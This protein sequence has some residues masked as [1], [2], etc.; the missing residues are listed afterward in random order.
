MTA[1]TSATR[2]TAKRTRPLT[3]EEV[4]ALPAAVDLVTAG[5]AYGIGRTKS[6]ELARS[7]KFPCRVLLVGNQYRVPKTALLESLGLPSDASHP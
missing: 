1:N 5:R 7:G 3:T 4:L 2:K 6:H